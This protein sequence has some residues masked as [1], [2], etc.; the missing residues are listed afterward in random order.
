MIGM[1]ETDQELLDEMI[2][3]DVPE[4]ESSTDP[5]KQF[6][7][8]HPP[9]SI[10][11]IQES[12]E[13]LSDSECKHPYNFSNLSLATTNIPQY[14]SPPV[15]SSSEPSPE[16]S[17]MDDDKN[18]PRG[19][20]APDSKDSLEVQLTSACEDLSE[21][22]ISGKGSL[23]TQSLDG[24]LKQESSESEDEKQATVNE[25]A[26][27]VNLKVD[28]DYEEDGRK[29]ISDFVLEEDL[30]TRKSITEFVTAEE[31][32]KKM[33][34]QT[35]EHKIEIV[36]TDVTT[37]S[38][39]DYEIVTRKE[40]EEAK[41]II[42][43][44]NQ[45]IRV[46]VAAVESSTDD[47]LGLG[48]LTP[49]P[50]ILETSTKPSLDSVPSTDTEPR[51]SRPASS[52]YSEPER[53]DDSSDEES[54]KQQ[55]IQ[56]ASSDYSDI[57]DNKKQQQPMSPL[58]PTLARK[59]SASSAVVESSSDYDGEIGKPSY[60]RDPDTE[61]PRKSSSASSEYS[62]LGEKTEKTQL[63]KVER[64][65]DKE[66]KTE[67]MGPSDNSSDD[68]DHELVIVQTKIPSAV[69]K[70]VERKSSTSSS[71]ASEK[72]EEKAAI[73]SS[74]EA[75][76]EKKT[77]KASV[78]SEYSDFGDKIEE[79]KDGMMTKETLRP[80][81]S[82]FSDF[83]VSKSP[84]VTRKQSAPAGP[85]S[86]DLK[87]DIVTRKH[88]EQ[89]R[90]PPSGS[91][92]YSDLGEKKPSDY[93]GQKTIDIQPSEDLRKQSAPA[94]PMASADIFE[95]DMARK[96]SEQVIRRPSESSDYSDIGEKKPTESSNYSAVVEKKK[97]TTVI[98]PSELLRKQ[99]AP[100]RPIS[101]DYSDLDIKK[102]IERKF[103][104]QA[105][106]PSGSSD[107]SDVS[108]KKIGKQASESSDYSDV[109]EKRKSAVADSSA[110]SEPEVEP[111]R[112]KV[113]FEPGIIQVMIHKGADLVNQEI[114]GKSDPYVVLKFRGQEFRSKTLR[115]TINPEWSFGTDLIIS[116]Q[117]DSSIVIEV[118]DDDNGLDSSL[119][120]LKLSLV[121][122]IQRSDEE[123]RWYSLS[124]CKHGRV[125]VSC[126]YTAM[127][128]S[129]GSL[130]A[131]S[132]ADIEKPRT[133]T[134]SSSSSEEEGTKDQATVLQH[135]SSDSSDPREKQ[136]KGKGHKMSAD[137]SDTDASKRATFRPQSSSEQSDTDNDKRANESSSDYDSTP[138]RMRKNRPA[139]IIS[140]TSSDYSNVGGRR[141]QSQYLDDEYDI[142]TEEEAA[143]AE[144]S[145]S[146]K[147]ET[148][149]GSSSESDGPEI[150]DA[151]PKKT[152]T[153]AVKAAVIAAATAPVSVPLS[154][155]N[156]EEGL[157]FQSISPQPNTT[158]HPPSSSVASLSSSIQRSDQ[159]AEAE[160][161]FITINSNTL[162]DIG[163]LD[164][165]G[166][167]AKQ[168]EKV[169][170]QPILLP[171]SSSSP[172]SIDQS[173]RGGN[174]VSDRSEGIEELRECN[175]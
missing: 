158:P 30:K 140:D 150:E 113:K 133:R 77:R 32:Y 11:S 130:H 66:D 173:Q 83:E 58:L 90:R 127:S 3:K 75:E 38:D 76:V 149:T 71:V 46:D 136:S 50:S 80:S 154:G 16:M 93:S 8:S 87:K 175:I 172:N 4:S 159:H 31:E 100:A 2:I 101:S 137:T 134:Y 122:A 52:I 48:L 53:E 119:G 45:L 128:S 68:D 108:E 125:F 163:H 41:V 42:T 23:D 105:R 78:S 40:V 34:M 104:E 138:L 35:S 27:S 82:D 10:D 171:L 139:S 67:K 156:G 74:S 141:P 147:K 162:E 167:T 33:E 123:S 43:A 20:A 6:E 14:S 1:K 56:S 107:Y 170:Q 79:A 169:S 55:R 88:S 118:Y 96:H 59:S 36:D 39:D 25:R 49:V 89:V 22:Q 62:D 166:T 116:E 115:N 110:E 13:E 54:N 92:D 151:Q 131:F 157:L 160:D 73:E 70:S 103:S 94:R 144:K 24:Q 98:E 12:Q 17:H 121:D 84:A 165:D 9:V 143:E 174:S 142:I 117:Y 106:R 124:N 95:I 19:L 47:D 99:S 28:N 129:S 7:E 60:V 51:Q 15:P 114:M 44:D 64:D 148:A 21:S 5:V 112:P 153:T 120:T 111:P 155:P 26:A 102:D 37:T 146:E 61:K 161:T 152:N 126:I 69:E 86:S 91:S 85:I 145:K 81:S 57:G 29:S 132:K 72:K 135:S 168:G 63:E 109:G 65:E 164:R 18:L 97:P